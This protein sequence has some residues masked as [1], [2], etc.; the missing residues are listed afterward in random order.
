MEELWD[1]PEPGRGELLRLV[2]QLS[3][4]AILAQFS[5]V[6]MQYI[7][8]AMVGSLGANATAAIGL[9]ASTTWLFGGVSIAA[10]TGF[11]VQCAQLI[12]AGRE[13]DA[14]SVFRQALVSLTALGLVLG[15][16][17][18]GISGGL[19]VWLGGAPEIVSDA[20]WYFR[21][22]AV[23]I[24]FALL[25]QLAGGML[26]CSGDMRTPSILNVLLCL[27]DVVF[28]F[29]FIF[30]TRALG[31]FTV[32]GLGL[33][34]AGASLGTT[35]AEVVTALLM[36]YAAAVQ[37]PR[38]NL[39]R[40]GSWRL[41]RDC[42]RTAA[43]IAVPQAFERMVLGGAQVVSTRIISPL[44]TV[45]VAANS[46]GVTAE[47]L[48]YMPGYGIAAAATTL[49]GQSIGAGRKD[50]AR[51]FAR[52]SVAL[53]IG[54]MACMGVL[55]YLFA[56]AMFALLTPDT[57]VQ[58]LGV[59]VLRIEALAEPLFGASIV[60]TG[61][62]RGA[63]DSLVPSVMNLISMWGVRITMAAYLAPRCGLRGVWTAMCV[64]LCV[65]GTLFLIRLF[66]EKWLE[67][68]ALT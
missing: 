32:P 28:N 19:P 58:A 3:L 60:V 67:K 14:R 30:P 7:D 26:Q 12:G 31:G 24:P 53:G 41:R 45:A 13:E 10:A 11:S 49:V 6:A 50:L 21:I 68:G 34:V 42:L 25:R 63:G 62:L 33:G 1:R 17:A 44:G 37:S 20:A 56:P 39:R 43:G 54:I 57:A 64:E 22:F 15:A 59:S 9:V 38:L 27:F 46:L 16:L 2:V 8:A 61:A 29:F 23:S 55:L 18:L 51:R 4:P 5:S 66:R 65:R 52:L 47:S 48:G 40:G 35:M 36:L